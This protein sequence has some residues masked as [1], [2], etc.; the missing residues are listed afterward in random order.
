MT[1]IV[2]VIFA[3]AILSV[4]IWLYFEE[5]IF[6]LNKDNFTTQGENDWRRYVLLF[7]T[8]FA[9][10]MLGIAMWAY[11]YATIRFHLE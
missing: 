1:W 8:I 2:Y 9:I 10:T 4:L 7:F 5:I 6:L 3:L 11:I